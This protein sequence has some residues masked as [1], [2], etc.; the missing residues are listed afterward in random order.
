MNYGFLFLVMSDTD[1]EN[2]GELKK[3]KPT[4]LIIHSQIVCQSPSDGLS[5]TL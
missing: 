3:N 4:L 1:I 2:P 5:L